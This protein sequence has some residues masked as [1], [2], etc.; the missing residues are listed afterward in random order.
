MEFVQPFSNHDARNYVDVLTFPTQQCDVLGQHAPD[1]FHDVLPRRAL[2]HACVGRHNDI[3][4]GES[5]SAFGNANQCPT[6]PLRQTHGMDGVTPQLGLVPLPTT[7]RL[8]IDT[9]SLVMQPLDYLA[10][11]NRSAGEAGLIA[12][13]SIAFTAPNE[14]TLEGCTHLYSTAA[15]PYPGM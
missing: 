1:P 3:L 8:H 13:V 12:G 4:P 15:T 10:L 2:V 11:V 14:N 9:G 7:A 6:A 5:G